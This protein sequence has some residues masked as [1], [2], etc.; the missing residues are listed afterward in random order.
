MTAAIKLVHNALELINVAST[1]S[2]P[3]PE[4][5]ERGLMHLGNL[6]ACTNVFN[7][8]LGLIPPR[9]PKDQIGEPEWATCILELL[10]AEKLAPMFQVTLSILLAN[11][12]RKA[13]EDLIIL[14]VPNE[15]AKYP[16][17][18]PVGAGSYGSGR[19]FFPHADDSSVT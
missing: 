8:N 2:P 11:Q 14:T 15:T 6:I 19:T 12:I 16:G 5:E 18:L 17:T 9:D 13:K 1:M 3:S 10:L 4:Q 7:Q